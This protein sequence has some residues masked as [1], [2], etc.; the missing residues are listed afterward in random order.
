MKPFKKIILSRISPKAEPEARSLV[1]V[2]HFGGDSETQECGGGKDGAEQENHQK[3]H[4]QSCLGSLPVS[5]VLPWLL[6]SCLSAR[7]DLGENQVE[8]T[9]I[10]SR[11]NTG[12]PRIS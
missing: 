6:G 10:P 1:W 5:N 12:H 2:F 4:Y 9:V 11:C 7:E 3:M 8:I